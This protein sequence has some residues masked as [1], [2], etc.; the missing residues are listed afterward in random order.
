MT[1]LGPL[2]Y[3]LGIQVSSTSDGFYISQEMYIQDLL[4]RAALGDECTVETPIELNVQLHASNGDP[5]SDP[6]RYRHL[7]GSLV[8]LVVT[9]PDISYPI[10]ILSQFVSDPTLVY[11]SHLLHVLRYLQSMISHRPF[12][13]VPAPYSFRPTL[14]FVNRI[15]ALKETTNSIK[16]HKE[17]KNYNKILEKP[18]IFNL[19][20]VSTAR[21]RCRSSLSR[22][23][24]V[25]CGRE[26]AERV[27]KTTSAPKTKKKEELPMKLLDDP[28][29]PTAR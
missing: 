2:R 14:F 12:S 29:I 6:T 26:V 8:Y 21:R 5:L 23:N 4:A 18:L 20:T 28:K 15:L 1:D 19:Q 27:K 3:F 22:P 24:V 17:N 9:R 11:Y 7:V 25:G 16:H 10:H 13:L